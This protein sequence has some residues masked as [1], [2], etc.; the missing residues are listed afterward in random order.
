MSDK[1][2]LLISLY[3]P[4][5]L[6]VTST[7]AGC[8]LFCSLLITVFTAFEVMSAENHI[9]FTT[10]STD[11]QWNIKAN[12]AVYTIRVCFP[13]GFQMEWTQKRQFIEGWRFWGRIRGQ[14]GTW[15]PQW[16]D[17]GTLTS[18]TGMGEGALTPGRAVMFCK[19]PP[20]L[21]V[22]QPPLCRAGQDFSNEVIFPS[23]VVSLAKHNT[24]I[25]VR[26]K[27]SAIGVA[28]EA[29]YTLLGYE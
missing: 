8:L 25:D 3:L 4:C 5:H 11:T 14:D 12:S 27:S 24:N 17:R 20:S 6:S 23:L 7:V 29:F 10:T 28:G 22:Y 2:W 21:L 13:R 19:S 26:R 16:T 15:N 1:E 18:D 9:W